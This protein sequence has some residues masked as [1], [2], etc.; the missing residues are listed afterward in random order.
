VRRSIRML[1]L[2]CAAV[3][4]IA[5]T[6][7]AAT[8][9]SSTNPT[10]V[11]FGSVPVGTTSAPRQ[12]TVTTPCTTFVVT[13]LSFATDGLQVS[14][15]TTGDFSV[16]TNNCPATLAPGLLDTSVSCVLS[17]VFRPTAAGTR[18]GTLS[19]GTE[20]LIPGPGP[21]VSLSGT[22][23]APTSAAGTQATKRKKC[24]KKHK[25]S[26]SSAKK[27]RCKRKKKGR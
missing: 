7:A 21:M 3:G 19:T 14:L 10:I 15:A 6:P 22:G 18:S 2:T 25:R 16:A 12:I 24:K 1:A 20:G 8:A 9:A 5:I 13:C 4:V 23:V 27:R 26:A 11:N 17:A